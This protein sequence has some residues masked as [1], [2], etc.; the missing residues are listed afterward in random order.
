MVG[1]QWSLEEERCF[2]QRIIPI[3]PSRAGIDVAVRDENKW[4]ELVPLMERWM[5]EEARRK[6]TAQMLYEHWYQNYQRSYSPNAYQ[7]VRTYLLSIGEDPE[8][9]RPNRPG[10]SSRRGGVRKSVRGASSRGNRSS[11]QSQRES[12]S[13]SGR[14]T[15][16]SS[17]PR[18]GANDTNTT[19]SETESR[20]AAPSATIDHPTYRT[21]ATAGPSH[22]QVP[23]PIMSTE[24]SDHGFTARPVPVPQ[25]FYNPDPRS[26]DNDIREAALRLTELAASGR[27]I[28][29]SADGSEHSGSYFGSVASGGSGS[30]YGEYGHRASAH[31]YW[32]QFQEASNGYGVAPAR[33]QPHSGHFSYPNSMPVV[34]AYSSAHQALAPGI[35][36]RGPVHG[37]P[38]QLPPPIPPRL[39]AHCEQYSTIQGVFSRGSFNPSPTEVP[40][41]SGQII[42][43]RPEVARGTAGVG[44]NHV[45]ERK[46]NDNGQWVIAEI[47]R[48]N[49]FVTR[50][51]LISSTISQLTIEPMNHLEVPVFSPSSARQVAAL[52]VNRIELNAAGS[53]GEG[54]L[55]PSLAE[56]SE[57]LSSTAAAPASQSQR[58]PVRVMIR[59][60]GPPPAPSADFIYNPQELKAG[61]RDAIV[62]FKESNLMHAELG[63][64]FVFGI[65]KQQASASDEV[66]VDVDRNRELV[67][68]AQ[69]Y[70]CVFH[71]AFDDV[72]GSTD[73]QEASLG[74]A[75]EDVVACG[76]GGIL[77]SGG[78][79]NAPDNVETLRHIVCLASARN[80]EIIAGGGVRARNAQ[81]I[82]REALRAQ[83]PNDCG[84]DKGAR[85]LH[86]S[87][88]TS[89]AVGDVGDREI[90][91]S[92]VTS[93][94]Q[95]LRHG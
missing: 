28:S 73:R 12:R 63:D 35:M 10:S 17:S 23:F 8:A 1:A 72:V 33:H 36:G 84:D 65:L 26:A 78:P 22:Q 69:P 42:H 9:S 88:L 94:L 50:A 27:I 93:L 59:P 4:K 56:L 79:G 61:M 37:G 46:G 67:R 25:P 95:V 85:W 80:I 11:I 58:V 55:T 30:G 44:E 29:P 48:Q 70:T 16:S 20:G 14:S 83:G 60:R 91:K 45:Q 74:Q 53:Y 86:S 71:R 18:N 38:Y 40:P 49:F 66:V 75:L 64:G 7:F 77:T 62:A 68:L 81:S 43:L 87:C 3:S 47:A 82:I 21:Y 52:G 6:Y 57:L 2:W 54:G 32:P 41:N 90:D 51:R 5:G 15:L 76:F 31:G 92:E 19:R 34:G 13:G 89:S 39:L 24:Q